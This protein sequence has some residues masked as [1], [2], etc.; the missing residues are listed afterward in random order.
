MEIAWL[1][2]YDVFV[3][4]VFGGLGWAYIGLSLVYF[5]I[6]MFSRMSPMTILYLFI[7]WTTAYGIM[8]FGGTIAMIFTFISVL[9]ASYSVITWFTRTGG[10]GT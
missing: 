2:L 10:W 8:M 5:L 9:Y 6:G 1:N 3:N 4:T 7:V